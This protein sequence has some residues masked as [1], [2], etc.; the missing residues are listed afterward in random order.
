VES[1]HQVKTELSVQNGKKKKRI[2][3]RKI[4]NVIEITSIKKID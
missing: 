4:K 2:K 1:K 3:K